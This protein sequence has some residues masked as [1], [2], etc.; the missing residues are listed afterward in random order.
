MLHQFSREKALWTKRIIDL[1]VFC[2][3][4]QKLLKSKAETNKW[5]YKNKLSS[6][7]CGYRNGF[8]TLFAVLFLIERWKKIPDEKG[9]G[10][11]V[12]MDLSKTFDTLNH[13]LLIAKLSVY[14]FNNESLKLIRSYLTNKWQRTK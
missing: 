5:T 6:Y 4:F 12:L 9:F 13:E 1:S 2:L 10:G 11:A 8:S 14:G 3:R 7:L